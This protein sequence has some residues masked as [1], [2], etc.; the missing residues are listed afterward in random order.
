VATLTRASQELF[1]RQAD[2]RFDSLQALWAHC[3]D[4]REQSADR[5][6]PPASLEIESNGSLRV[7]AGN[8]GAFSL[9]D[10][11]FSQLCRFAGVSKDTV[12]RLSPDTA[13]RVLGETL[14]KGSGKPLQLLT[15]GD[16]L[17]SVH[18]VQ[19]AR[20]W[21]AD[22]VQTLQE[23]AVDFQPPQK[24][25]NGATGLYAG[26]QDLFAFL[27]DPNGWT[28]IGGDA[29]APGFF[30]WNSEVGRRSLG[31]STFWFQA[32]CQ[33]HIV[34]DATEVVEWTRKHTGNVGDG[35]GEIRRMIAALVEK[36][37]ARKDGF[38]K[39]VAKAMREKLGDDAEEVLKVLHRQ[40]VSRPLAARALELAQEQGRF[41]VWSVVD[42][43]TR[44]ARETA[45]AGSRIEADEKAS[46]LLSLV[47][48]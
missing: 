3:R 45:F 44:L 1:R 24:G 18:G 13:R 37:D 20:L 22:L 31:V 17:R 8:D 43:L 16:T 25:F 33:N 42:A 46:H 12:N 48:V 36:R 26:E 47:S 35:L 15:G 39:V 30:V 23:F 32:V 28:D 14:P 5:W 41:T 40:G 21:N 11:S 4:Q 9:N 2:E 10:W 6:H 27:I 19:Y 29:F 38:A 7:V 34:W